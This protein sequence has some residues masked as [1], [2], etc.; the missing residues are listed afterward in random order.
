MARSTK[1]IFDH[2]NFSEYNEKLDF[3]FT[4]NEIGV[5]T[6]QSCAVDKTKADGAP[7]LFSVEICVIKPEE[8]LPTVQAYRQVVCGTNFVHMLY[9]F[10]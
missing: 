1:E 7:G 10:M 9:M 3:F 4:A 5:I 8:T 2:S 6:S